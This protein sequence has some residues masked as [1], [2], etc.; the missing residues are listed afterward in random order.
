MTPSDYELAVGEM[1]LLRK[2][3]SRP[4]KENESR[5]SKGLLKSLSLRFKGNRPGIRKTKSM[6][7]FKSGPDA[8]YN[9]TTDPTGRNVI[10]GD[11][12]YPDGSDIESEAQLNPR[13]KA[14]TWARKKMSQIHH[15]LKRR[16][17][18]T[19]LDE[20]SNIQAR[21]DKSV[22]CSATYELCRPISD[23]GN[24]ETGTYSQSMSHDFETCSENVT[25]TPSSF[26]EMA[27]RFFI[28]RWVTS[29]LTQFRDRRSREQRESRSVY[30]KASPDE[31][32]DYSS[33]SW[34]TDDP[35]YTDA[36]L[37]YQECR[38][39]M[40]NENRQ[41]AQYFEL[42]PENRYEIVTLDEDAK[43]KLS[44]PF[45]LSSNQ[46]AKLGHQSKCNGGNIYGEGSASA[47]R[48]QN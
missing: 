30:E 43:P 34:C 28:V 27:Q 37:H 39:T 35:V 9:V 13:I 2:N 38:N 24:D 3:E 5:Q 8:Y 16:K 45:N 1:S 32:S 41:S 10:S 15:T 47:P 44:L 21:S 31:A 17:N 46:Y 6:S 36:S 22:S 29:K 33:T 14:S 23:E 42:E 11:S 26:P 19:F 25:N 12:N 20:A 18:V 40:T 7:S 48:S 4:Y